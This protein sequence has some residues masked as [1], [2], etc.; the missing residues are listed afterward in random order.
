LNEFFYLNF[1]FFRL[2][3]IIGQNYEFVQTQNKYEQTVSLTVMNIHE[4]T[5]NICSTTPEPRVPPSRNNIEL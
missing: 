1:E 2:T 3:D 4:Y 5:G